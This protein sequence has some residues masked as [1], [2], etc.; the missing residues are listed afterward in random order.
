[1]L[2]LSQG[3]DLL[4]VGLCLKGAIRS[5]IPKAGGVEGR[6]EVLSTQT[7]NHFSLGEKTGVHEKHTANSPA[8]VDVAMQRWQAGERDWAAERGTENSNMRGRWSEIHVSHISKMDT[9]SPG[10]IKRSSMWPC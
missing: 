3:S 1:M 8:V 6:A 9:G 4:L 2:P 5:K 7:G 10:E